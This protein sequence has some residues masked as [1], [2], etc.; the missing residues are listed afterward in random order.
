MR[1]AP[2]SLHAIGKKLYLVAVIMLVTHLLLAWLAMSLYGSPWALTSEAVMF[3]PRSILVFLNNLVAGSAI[4]MTVVA[5]YVFS[6][7]MPQLDGHPPVKVAQLLAKRIG[8]TAVVLMVISLV[9][10]SVGIFVLV[11]IF[12]ATST[13]PSVFISI[14]NLVVQMF[15]PIVPAVCFV[16]ALLVL[17]L[18]ARACSDRE[19]KTS[20]KEG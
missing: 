5:G 16:A 7:V 2:Q 13:D 3:N 14:P 4:M 17:P 15:D 11:D 6:A 9:V 18:L 12:H 19:E 10:R 20:A 8:K 1:V